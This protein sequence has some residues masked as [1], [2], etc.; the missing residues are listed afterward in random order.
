MKKSPVILFVIF[1]VFFNSCDAVTR[2]NEKENDFE[3]S[4]INSSYDTLVVKD[5][6]IPFDSLEQLK[7]QGFDTLWVDSI[8]NIEP[9]ENLDDR[10]SNE[11]NNEES[12]CL[13]KGSLDI[14]ISVLMLGNSLL[15]GV[16]AK[17]TKLLTCAGYS[18]H[19]KRRSMLL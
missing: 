7:S 14:N 1:I 8:K 16:E 11:I 15:H 18:A 19:V 9:V 4:E 3:N 6:L 10:E 5:E 13:A 2:D 17:L 12:L